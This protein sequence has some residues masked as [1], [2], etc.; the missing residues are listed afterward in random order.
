MQRN[1]SYLFSSALR[2]PYGF[3]WA[4]VLSI[5][6][7]M[8]FIHVSD[9]SMKSPQNANLV[10]ANAEVMQIVGEEH[11]LM[12]D[13]LQKYTEARRQNDLVAEEEM[14]RSRADEQAAMLAEA[15]VK[16]AEKRL[17]AVA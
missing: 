12:A 7:G 13:Y 14:S 4:A 1:C 9:T 3:L 8:L 6:G 11:E 17:L 5:F 2:L 10:P 16:T 15:E